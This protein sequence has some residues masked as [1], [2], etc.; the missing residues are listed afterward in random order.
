MANPTG[1]NQYSKRGSPTKRKQVAELLKQ[2]RYHAA[3]LKTATD[4]YALASHKRQA[5]VNLRMA[6]TRK[7]KL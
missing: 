4:P 7:A 6:K 2:S 5:A 3:A 1:I